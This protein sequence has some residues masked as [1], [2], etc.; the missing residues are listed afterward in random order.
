[1]SKK[2]IRKEFREAV[3]ERD[4]YTCRLC[5]R[6]GY[7]KNAEVKGKGLALDSHHIVDRSELPGGGYVVSNGISLCEADHLKAEK[8]H[9]SGGKEWE[10]GMHPDDLYQIIGSSYDKAFE[11]ASKLDAQ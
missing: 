2:L 11:D 1:M 9:I 6:A 5:G 4:R 7:D 3:F 10:P 8:Y